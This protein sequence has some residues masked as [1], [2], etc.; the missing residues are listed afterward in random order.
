MHKLLKTKSEAS[1]PTVGHRRRACQVEL[2]SSVHSLMFKFIFL[3]GLILGEVIRA[4]YRLRHGQNKKQN[5]IV[6]DRVTRWEWLRMIGCLVG[7]W[8]IPPFYILTPL[9]SFADYHLP[10]W[11]A[12]VGVAIFIFALWL[13]FKSHT[14]LGGNWQARPR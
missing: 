7:M 14:T 10:Q 9:L 2:E 6:D 4:P 3:V 13:L 8:I 12:Q 11:V 1:L 5:R